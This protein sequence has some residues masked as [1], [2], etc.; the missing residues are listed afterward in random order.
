MFSTKRIESTFL[1]KSNSYQ[2][3]SMAY[4]PGLKSDYQNLVYRPGEVNI[5]KGIIKKNANLETPSSQ[6]NK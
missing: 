3:N 1:P 5:H 4:R 6:S 2:K